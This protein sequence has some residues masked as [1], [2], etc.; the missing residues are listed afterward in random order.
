VRLAAAFSEFRH[1]LN[2]ALAVMMALAEM[3]QRD[4]E[5]IEKLAASVLEKGRAISEKLRVFTATFNEIIQP[6][7][8]EE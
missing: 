3:A 8:R 6:S 2:N 5:R 4:P 7:Q 1:A